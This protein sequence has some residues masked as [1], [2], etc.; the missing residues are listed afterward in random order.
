[1]PEKKTK[2]AEKEAT[3]IKDEVKQEAK[4]LEKKMEK[5]EKEADKKVNELVNKAAFIDKLL[6]ASWIKEI[7]KL[8]FIESANKRVR[9][10]LELIC[11]ILW[12]IILIWWIIY[13]IFAIIAFVR[14]LIWLFSWNIGIFLLS[15]IALASAILIIMLWRGLIKMKKWLPAALVAIIA[16]D[17]VLFVLSIFLWESFGFCLL[18]IIF[19]FVFILFVLKNKDLFNN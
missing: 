13:T 3:P 1:M 8:S 16:V 6:N 10:N 5:A 4:E 14:W 11:K 7:L 17:L 2:A 18:E 12:W 15:L 9:K 19:Y